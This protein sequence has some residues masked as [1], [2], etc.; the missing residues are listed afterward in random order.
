MQVDA[1]TQLVAQSIGE[2]TQVA[3][4]IIPSDSKVLFV[5]ILRASPVPAEV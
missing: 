4:V 1:F 3:A 2:E 5:C